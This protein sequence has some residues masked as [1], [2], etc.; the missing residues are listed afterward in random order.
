[1]RDFA[2]GAFSLRAAPRDVRLVYGGFL[3]LAVVGFATEFAVA[4][5]RIGVTPTAVATY[6][7]GG[8][9]GPVMVFPKTFAQLLDI[10]HAHAFVMGLVFLVLAHLFLATR[11]SSRVKA[12]VLVVVFSGTA[13]DL[14]GPWLVRYG[15]PSLAWVVLG[16][17]AFQAVGYSALF[18]LTGWECLVGPVRA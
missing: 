3:V 16:A 4:C 9:A 13:A 18:A 2:R 12:T 17:W 7:R 14:L 10:T 5:G 11:V 8:E 6:Y 1:V 15:A